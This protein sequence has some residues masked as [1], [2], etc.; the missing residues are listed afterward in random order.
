MTRLILARAW[1]IVAALVAVTGVA[2]VSA[3]QQQDPRPSAGQS[4]SVN[5]ST[6][7]IKPSDLKSDI[8]FTNERLSVNVERRSLAR[9]VEEISDRAGIPVMLAGKITHQLLSVNFRDL[10]LDQGL[11]QIFANYDS[12]FFYSVDEQGISRLRAVWIYPKGGGQGIAPVPAE[13]WASTNELQGMLSDKDPDVRGRAIETLAE[14]KRQA[15]L[16]AVLKSLQDDDGQV[17]VRALYGAL[18][19]DM[20][21]PEAVLSNLLNDTSPDVR[22][23]ALQA[24]A[25]SP[26]A[27]PIAERALNDSSEAVRALAHEIAEPS[28]DTTD[29]SQQL[30][31]LQNNQPQQNQ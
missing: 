6:Q 19:A 10:P 26:N 3:G 16:E 22:L 31:Q 2:P 30:N 14:R 11:R 28:D 18:K 29:Q 20:E 27:R 7:S 4:T 17:R 5:T 21:I 8:S 13:K 15:A 23:V 25:K 9:L 1:A 12:F 24:L